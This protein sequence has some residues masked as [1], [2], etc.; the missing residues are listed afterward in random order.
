VSL[1]NDWVLAAPHLSGIIN[2]TV[3]SLTLSDELS[4][5]WET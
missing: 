1:N 2:L 5:S 3:E 4:R